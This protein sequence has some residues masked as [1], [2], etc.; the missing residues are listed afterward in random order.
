MPERRPLN[1][2]R[3]NAN[4]AQAEMNIDDTDESTR[5]DDRVQNQRQ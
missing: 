4:A 3:E 2:N 5:D 1:R